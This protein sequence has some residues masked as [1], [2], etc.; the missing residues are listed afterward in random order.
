MPF[1]TPLRTEFLGYSD[2]AAHHRLIEPLT[3]CLAAPGVVVEI[4]V[5]AGF[6]SDFASVPWW[7]R[8]LLPADG[9]WTP[10]A[11]VHDYLCVLGFNG[12]LT[13]AIFRAAMEDCGVSLRARLVMYYAVR[14]YQA[15]KGRI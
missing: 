3:W 1:L 13:D 2:G 4:A 9:P 7:A 11:V 6:V 8:W 15:R 10:A 5:P 14:A 12:I